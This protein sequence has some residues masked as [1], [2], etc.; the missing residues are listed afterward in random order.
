VSADEQAVLDGVQVRLIEVG[1][2]ERFDRLL[3]EQH[4]LHNAEMVGARLCYVAQYAVAR[5]ELRGWAGVSRDLLQGQRLAG[6]GA[7]ARLR[8]Q[9]RGLPPEV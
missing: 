8:T 1:E 6:T 9:P 2:Q 5:G 4:Y 7:D 3:I